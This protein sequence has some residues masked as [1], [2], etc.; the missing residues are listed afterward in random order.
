MT[1]HYRASLQVWDIL[2]RGL[3]REL[4]IPSLLVA[5]VLFV[6]AMTLLGTNVSEMRAAYGRV[7]Q[8]NEAIL[9]AA[10]VNT[11]ILRVEMIVRGYA[12]SGDPVYLRWQ[13]EAERNLR[14][15]VAGFGPLFS[16]TADERADVA[17]LRGLIEEHI[18]Y[19]DRLARQVPVDRQ[20][21]ITEIVDYGKQAKR[22]PI[23]DLLV[24][25]RADLAQRLAGQQEDAE[26]RVIGAYRYAIGISAV[27]LLFGALGF[28]LLIHNRGAGRRFG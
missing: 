13:E 27:A 3:L 16:A 23:E 1:P 10:M 4:G 11:D 22:R 28:A 12:L 2:D 24:D 20:R 5:L 9:Q 6:S 7:Q 14:A 8:S 26:A 25:M 17:A 19:F 18:A 15:R 21:V